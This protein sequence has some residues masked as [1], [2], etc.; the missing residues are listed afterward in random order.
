[1]SSPMP[2]SEVS[3]EETTK[4]TWITRL[5]KQHSTSFVVFIF[6][7]AFIDG[8]SRMRTQALKTIYKTEFQLEA[9]DSQKYL[10]ITQL[11]T[12]FRMLIGV[13]ID[14]RSLV[15]ERKYLVTAC[16]IMMCLCFLAIIFGG[17][18]TPGSMCLWVFLFSFFNEFIM[19]SL[20]SYALQQGRKDIQC[21]QQD[22][23]SLK[24]VGF[25]LAFSCAALT[26]AYLTKIEQPRI[27]FVISFFLSF[28]GACQC[29]FLSKELE[30]NEQAMMKDKE[31]IIYEREQRALNP[32]LPPDHF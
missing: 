8:S 13:L 29:L 27:V 14:S 3:E 5:T 26:V 30:L 22:M 24:F 28:M 21:G 2:I 16:H 9:T 23:Q 17:A 10:A 1:M 15:S 31:L 25:G 20:A 4:S 11:P 6:L 12:M 32:D 18:E 7:T 19:A